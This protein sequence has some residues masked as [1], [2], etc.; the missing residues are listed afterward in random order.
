MYSHTV[1]LTFSPSTD[2]RCAGF[3]QQFY[4]GGDGVSSDDGV[5]N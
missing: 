1:Y 4:D 3:L 5:V 2:L